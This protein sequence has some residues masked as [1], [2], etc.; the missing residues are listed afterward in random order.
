MEVMNL[1]RRETV[2][3]KPR[4]LRTKRAQK[5]FVP[6]NS[7]VRMQPALH[8]HARAAERNR[9]VNLRAN[10]VDRAHVGVGRARPAI[11]RAESTH[12]IAD[13]RIVNVSID[14]VGNYVIRMTS[15]PHFVGRGA[16]ASY[17]V[18][19]EQRRAIIGVQPFA[20]ER[21]LQNRLNIDFSHVLSLLSQGTI[22]KA[23][24]SAAQTI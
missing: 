14:D 4:V 10:L 13:V 24:N 3:L 18:G 15:L 23:G 16:D 9:L 22:L 21:F 19:L 2:K 6:L 12:D 1:R 8:Q 7:K 20:G 11:E 17:V 5:I